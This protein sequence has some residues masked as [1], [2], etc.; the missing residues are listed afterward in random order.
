M[1]GHT[2]AIVDEDSNIYTLGKK[3]GQGGQGIVYETTARNILLKMV[4][5]EMGNP[6]REEAQR[7]AFI[8]DMNK[9][10]LL[11]LDDTIPVAKPLYLLDSPYLGYVMELLSDMTPIKDLIIP[12]EENAIAFY[13]KTGGL[14]RR[15][16]LLAK[17]ASILAKLHS[18]GIVY[19][20]ISPG[21]ILVSRDVSYTE[22]WLIDTD[23]MR[24]ASEVQRRIFTTG[25]GAPEIV[26]GQGYNSIASD[27]FSLAALSFETL[28]MLA[29]FDGNL[30]NGNADSWDDWDEEGDDVFTKAERGELPWVWDRE[31]QSNH[32]NKGLHKKYV[33]TERLYDLLER[34]LGRKGRENPLSRPSALEFYH[35]F[36]EALDRTIRCSHCKATFFPKNSEGLC[37]YCKQGNAFYYASIVTCQDETPWDHETSSTHIHY[38]R[39]GQKLFDDTREAQFLTAAHNQ[40]LGLAQGLE[41]IIELKFLN[42]YVRIK[43]LSDN[44][45]VVYNEGNRKQ[46]HQD[47]STQVD[48]RERTVIEVAAPQGRATYFYLYKGGVT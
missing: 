28:S 40:P 20:D 22:V 17:T 10:R 3:I 33:L 48:L 27:L 21:N 46:L 24:Y 26:R 38:E 19:A 5:D 47:M 30:L 14:R 32:T 11:D 4:T 1:R 42:Y 31:D 15:L 43:S 41:T 34:T 16:L 18:R 35:A 37:P 9:V 12:D 8:E 2:G 23:Y 44:P 13:L 36:L 45:I 25:Y 39:I 29:P 7:D 6:V